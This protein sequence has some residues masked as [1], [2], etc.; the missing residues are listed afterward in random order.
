MYFNPLKDLQNTFTICSSLIHSHILGLYYNHTP[1]STSYAQGHLEGLEI[2]PPIM[3]MYKTA[4]FKQLLAE[5]MLLAQDVY[6]MRCKKK[7]IITLIENYIWMGF[8]LPFFIFTL[9]GTKST[10]TIL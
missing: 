10:S 4:T 3:Q 6:F 9:L 8:L 7:R 5:L 2:G 1:V